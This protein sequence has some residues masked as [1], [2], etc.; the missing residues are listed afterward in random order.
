MPGFTTV[1]AD[2]TRETVAAI[3]SGL[4]K[5]FPADRIA[6]D[7]HTTPQIVGLL[8]TEYGPGMSELADAAE[9]LR[10]SAKVNGDAPSHIAL[11]SIPTPVDRML[12]RIDATTVLL[13]KAATFPKHAAK[14]AKVTALI[15]E[16]RE[17]VAA[18]EKAAKVAL[19]RSLAL[20]EAKRQLAEAQARIAEL[21]ATAPKS[22]HH[23]APTNEP[24]LIR[25]WARANG[26]EVGMSGRVA[27]SVRDAW[28]AAQK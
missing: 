23:P 16:L 13:E 18:S 15:A 5:G 8:R 14:A 11:T 26:V 21:K 1:R 12:E 20:T 17:E 10:T 19:E 25:A 2:L 22:S 24:A 6:R 4:A 27:K 7:N 3:V 28:K 9:V